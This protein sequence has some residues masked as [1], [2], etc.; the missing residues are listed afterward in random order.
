MIKDDYTRVMS[1]FFAR[2]KKVDGP[3]ENCQLVYLFYKLSF[4]KLS[5]D[6]SNS[7]EHFALDSLEQC[8]TTSRDVRNLIGQTELV[9]ASYRVA[10]TDE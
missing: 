8:T 1:V 4:Y 7:W 2:V 9:D 5:L 3:T 6:S 10:T